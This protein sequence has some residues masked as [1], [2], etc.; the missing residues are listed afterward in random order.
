MVKYLL[1]LFLFLFSCTSNESNDYEVLEGISIFGIDLSHHNS[2]IKWNELDVSFVYLK[3]TEGSTYQDIKYLEYRD[4]C[5]KN[6]IPVGAYHFFTSSPGIKQFKNFQNVTKGKFN[7]IPVID[8]E[9][10]KIPKKQLQQELCIWIRACYNTYNTYPIIYTSEAFYLKYLSD[11][12]LII[13]CNVW[14][15][16]IDKHVIKIPHIMRQSEIK[17]IKGS[18][19]PIDC[20]LLYVS[21]DDIKLKN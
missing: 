7:L 10:C 15:G 4:S 19:Y 13:K 14:F 3:A 9:K 16:D 8:V 2:N 20:D 12:K 6:N 1:I 18:K 11:N 17:K 21:L 5:I